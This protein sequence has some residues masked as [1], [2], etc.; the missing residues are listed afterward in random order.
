MRPQLFGLMTNNY[1]Y[2]LG[3]ERLGGGHD[4]IDQ[5]QP[6]GLVQHFWQ[7]GLHPRALP[8][9]QYDDVEIGGVGA[10]RHG[11]LV[12]APGLQTA[13]IR[14]AWRVER[15]TER[16]ELVERSEIRIL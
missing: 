16:L 2:R 9:R 13:T 4:V 11:C 7:R 15:L 14:S 6:T 10:R 5:R 1:D 12:L 8:G 3:L